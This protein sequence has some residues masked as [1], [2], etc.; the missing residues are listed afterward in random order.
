MDILEIF[1]EAKNISELSR[2]LFNND[3]TKYRELAKKELLKYGINYDVWKSEKIYKRKKFCINC[4]K[5]LGK[6]QTKFCCSSC[7]ATYNNIQRGKKKKFCI[8]CG[9][10]LQNN[11]T[12][13]CSSDCHTQYDYDNFIKKWK[14][15]EINGITG[16]DGISKLIRRYLFEKYNNKC[17][18]CG[19]G[20][21]NEYTNKIPLQIHH[22]DGDCTNNKEENLQLLCPNCHSLTE[23]YGHSGKHQSKRLD[24]R[25]KHVQE[26]LNKENNG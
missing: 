15:G 8:N 1:N 5:E 18:K 23:N 19:W 12:K 20:E 14:N 3:S 17:E 11:Q 9:K 6:G 22:A 16:K 2:K 10:E 25:L 21:I 13:F 24:K 7:S 26:K 4:G